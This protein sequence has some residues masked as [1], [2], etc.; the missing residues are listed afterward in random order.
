MAGTASHSILKGLLSE[1]DNNPKFSHSYQE[2]E[3]RIKWVTGT[4]FG[5]ERAG[6]MRI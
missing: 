1:L 3:D 2:E 5:G 4:L 6:Y